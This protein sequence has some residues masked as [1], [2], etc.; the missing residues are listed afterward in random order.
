MEEAK[1]PLLT[2]EEAAQYLRLSVSQL[3][4]I[5]R[6]GLLKRIKFGEGPRARVL[7]C[8]DDLNHFIDAHRSADVSA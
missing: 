3:D 4:K 5:A 6:S 7:Y 8:A 1:S 2:R